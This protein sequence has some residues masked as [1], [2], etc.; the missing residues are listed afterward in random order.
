MGEAVLSVNKAVIL[1]A[2]MGER[3]YRVSSEYKLITRVY[4]VP[5]ILYSIKSIYLHG[6]R[7]FVVVVNPIYK[8]AI[9]FVIQDFIDRE[10]ARINVNYIVN[11]EPGKGNG[12]S[13]LLALKYGGLKGPFILSMADH[14]Y[15]PSVVEAL[16]ECYLKSN[17]SVLGGDSRPQYIDSSEA[18][19]I[20]VDEAGYVTSVGKVIE[21]YKYV[22]IGVH[23]F[24]AEDFIPLCISLDDQELS[25]LI[26]CV[27]KYRRIRV[28]DINGLPWT[29]IDTLEDYTSLVTGRRSMVL[30]EVFKEWRLRARV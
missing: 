15:S 19:K 22:D 4:G 11:N 16:E 21:S 30:E 17:T 18:T 26:T 1:A 10:G 8:E 5:L 7:E 24:N 2:G 27:S 20:S 23:L 9:R 12:Y 14:V 28:C 6:V 3:F 29:D 25:K 13:L